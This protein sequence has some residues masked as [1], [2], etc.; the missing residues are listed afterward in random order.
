MRSAPR[1]REERKH[2]DRRRGDERPPMQMRSAP[3]PSRSEVDPDSPFAALGA[4][5]LALE[6]RAQE[7]GSS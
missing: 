3:P 2:G 5:K 7:Q 4:L 1:R 6:K